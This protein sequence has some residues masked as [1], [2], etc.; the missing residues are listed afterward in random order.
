M[1]AILDEFSE[2]KISIYLRDDEKFLVV[3][4]YSAIGTEIRQRYIAKVMKSPRGLFFKIR[5]IYERMDRR[6]T[7]PVWVEVTGEATLKKAYYEEQKLGNAI[8]VRFK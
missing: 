1:Q 2:Q 7:P 5:S 3:G 4:D 8:R 6:E